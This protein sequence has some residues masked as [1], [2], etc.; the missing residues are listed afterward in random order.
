MQKQADIKTEQSTQKQN[1]HFYH[2]I[3]SVGEGQVVSQTVLRKP[4]HHT[5]ENETGLLSETTYTGGL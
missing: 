4:A 1:I 5:E 3:K 2:T